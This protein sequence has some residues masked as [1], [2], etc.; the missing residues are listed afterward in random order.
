MLKPAFL[1]EMSP[2]YSKGVFDGLWDLWEAVY[3]IYKLLLPPAMF[4]FCCGAACFLCNVTESESQQKTCKT[5]VK[6]DAK[7][8][9]PLLQGF[10]IK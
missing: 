7:V 8:E 1:Q 5:Q 10:Q 2:F 3:E 6:P 4:T 9:C